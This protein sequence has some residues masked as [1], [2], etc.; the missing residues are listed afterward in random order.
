LKVISRSTFDLQPVLDALC[1]TA[2]RLCGAEMGF[3]AT[4]KNGAYR[5]AV[6]P[7]VFSGPSTVNASGLRRYT[8]FRRSTPTSYRVNPSARYRRAFLSNSSPERTSRRSPT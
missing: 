6:L 3:L 8:E 1:Q 4:R 2:A 7:S 5:Y